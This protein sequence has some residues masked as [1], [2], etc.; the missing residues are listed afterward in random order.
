[1]RQNHMHDGNHNK[2]WRPNPHGKVR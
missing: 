1:V 2:P